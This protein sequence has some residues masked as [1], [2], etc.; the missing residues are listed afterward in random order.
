METHHT[1]IPAAP[2]EFTHALSFPRL[3]RERSAE[4][5]PP[6]SPSPPVSPQANARELEPLPILPPVDEAVLDSQPMVDSQ[7][8]TATAT[9]GTLASAQAGSVLFD[10]VPTRVWVWVVLSTLI[11]LGSMVVA[12]TLLHW[13]RDVLAWRYF[14][15]LSDADL[16]ALGCAIPRNFVLAVTG[17]L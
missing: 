1:A 9:V 11:V 2:L 4:E 7:A 13:R 14:S 15:R 17:A 3:A 6:P 16:L 8:S 12:W 10:A 5:S